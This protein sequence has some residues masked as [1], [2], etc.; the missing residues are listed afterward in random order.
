M[1]EMK[2]WLHNMADLWQ[3]GIILDIVLVQNRNE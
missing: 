1:S 2:V 3:I